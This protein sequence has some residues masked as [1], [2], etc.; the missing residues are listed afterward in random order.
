MV[1]W[2]FSAYILYI[3]RLG[4]RE[5]LL[6][7]GL[8][9]RRLVDCC[10]RLFDVFLVREGCNF[11]FGC[12]TFFFLFS[13]FFLPPLL[14]L[15]LYSESRKW[16]WSGSPSWCGCRYA[17][18]VVTLCSAC[19]FRCVRTQTCING[20]HRTQLGAVC[21]SFLRVC[22][23]ALMGTLIVWFPTQPFYEPWVSLFTPRKDSWNTFRSFL[24][25]THSRTSAV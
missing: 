10:Q 22:I 11:C 6:L 12:R 4:F 25:Q 23:C 18:G 13:F 21:I 20:E 19:L 3:R 8:L 2:W 14:L 5:I 9:R 1:L 7:G 16:E 15:L 24:W 17:E